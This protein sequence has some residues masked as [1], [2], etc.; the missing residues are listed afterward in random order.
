MAEVAE[1][2]MGAFLTGEPRLTIGERVVL[3]EL[4]DR[5]KERHE[6]HAAHARRVYRPEVAEAM[7]KSAERVE[8]I[9]VKLGL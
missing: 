4:L 9:K 5:E 7:A 8:R 1:E 3:R 6:R 2:G